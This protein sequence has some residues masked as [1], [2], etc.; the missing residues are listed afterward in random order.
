M[1]HVL[2]RSVLINLQIFANFPDMYYWHLWISKA[3]FS[4]PH[5]NN[6]PLLLKVKTHENVRAYLRLGSQE[7]LALKS[8]YTQPPA[9]YQLAYGFQL[10]SQQLLISFYADL[11][12]ESLFILLTLQ[13]EHDAL[14]CVL[15]S[16]TGWSKV[17]YFQF[18][19]AVF[20]LWGWE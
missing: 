8:L 13:F 9:I 12:C 11:N 10:L 2:F 1:T 14:P 6:L 20:F 5:H 16:M 18:I 17:F 19:S 4:I 7:F 15:I 3:D